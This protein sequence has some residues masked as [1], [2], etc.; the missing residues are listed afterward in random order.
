LAKTDLKGRLVHK[1]AA[2]LLLVAGALVTVLLN[3]LGTTIENTER[4]E[5]E[6][7][8]FAFDSALSHDEQVGTALAQLVA[9][10]LE[11]LA[12]AAER[13][14]LQVLFVRGFEKLTIR[15]KGLLR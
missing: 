3:N 12:V 15:V 2:V 7:Y 14:R 5:V 1:I 6:D 10:I 4:R 8:R 13:K 9:D 11:A